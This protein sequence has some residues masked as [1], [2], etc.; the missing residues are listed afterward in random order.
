MAGHR[1]AVQMHRL[2]EF[3]VVVQLQRLD[4]GMIPHSSG[5]DRPHNVGNGGGLDCHVRALMVSA[6]SRLRPTPTRSSS[7][8]PGRS[9]GNIGLL[10]VSLMLLSICL[11]SG[12]TPA[13]ARPIS[14]AAVLS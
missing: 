5:A 12:S 2:D 10:R 9:T 11:A 13:S 3:V 14:M 8:W 4:R 6:G 1:V 7:S